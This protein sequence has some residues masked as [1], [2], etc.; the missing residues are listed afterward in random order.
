[1]VQV[2]SG[3]LRFS[4]VAAA[5]AIIPGLLYGVGLLALG[6]EMGHGTATHAGV[7]LLGVVLVAAAGNCA[8]RLSKDSLTWRA[9]LGYIGVVGVVLLLLWFLVAPGANW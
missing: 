7:R 5:L 9:F 6:G 8:R 1:V 4:H 2:K 3:A